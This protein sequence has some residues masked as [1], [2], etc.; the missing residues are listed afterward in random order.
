[1][2]NPRHTSPTIRYH[3]K[4]P[5]IPRRLHSISTTMRMVFLVLVVLVPLATY[6]TLL[7][8]QPPGPSTIHNSPAKLLL[9]T[10]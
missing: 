5:C 9:G 8:P 10:V 7:L 1:M 3:H 2:L 6:S 4:Y